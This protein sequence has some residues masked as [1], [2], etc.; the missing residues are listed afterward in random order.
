MS[1]VKSKTENWM[2]HHAQTKNAIILPK[3]SS[4]CFFCFF[5]GVR[6]FPLLS[7]KPCF[8]SNDSLK[9]LLG[10]SVLGMTKVTVRLSLVKL[11]SRN[12]TFF[13]RAKL[14]IHIDMCCVK[15]KKNCCRWKKQLIKLKVLSASFC[16]DNFAHVIPAG[17][18]S[19]LFLYHQKF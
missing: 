17:Q 10:Y 8:W 1:G 19:I 9:L 6:F 13:F 2:C 7:S 18:S 4:N 16:F 3:M 5:L 14:I 12:L 11:L 15:E